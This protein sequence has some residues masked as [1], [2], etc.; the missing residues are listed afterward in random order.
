MLV[1]HHM[2]AV[3]ISDPYLCS[4]TLKINAFFMIAYISNLFVLEWIGLRLSS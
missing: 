2:I 3:M 4:I 1:C